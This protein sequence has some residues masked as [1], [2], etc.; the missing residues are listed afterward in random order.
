MRTLILIVVFVCVC[1]QLALA[2]DVT[3][4]ACEAS[5]SQ[6]DVEFCLGQDINI[7][8]IY[9][10]C[11]EFTGDNNTLDCQGYQIGVDPGAFLGLS[12]VYLNGGSNWDVQNC[13]VDNYDHSV[14]ASSGEN[15]T[16]SNTNHTTSSDQAF[17]FEG[18]DHVEIHDV[19]AIPGGLGGATCASS[20]CSGAYL[21]DS[22]L[23]GIRGLADWTNGVVE[24][25]NFTSV[26]AQAVVATSNWTFTNFTVNASNTAGSGFDWP[27][28]ALYNGEIYNAQQKCLE[29]SDNQYYEDLTLHH[30][31]YAIDTNPN[32]DG[33]HINRLTTHNTSIRAIR[34]Q[35]GSDNNL[36]EG[37]HLKHY[38]EGGAVYLDASMD[39][40]TFK[41]GVIEG[42]QTAPHGTLFQYWGFRVVGEHSVAD[43]P[44]GL[45]LTN[46]TFQYLDRGYAPRAYQGAVLNN[47][48]SNETGWGFYGVAIENHTVNGY[49]KEGCCQGVFLDEI[50]DLLVEASANNV[51]N[52]VYCAASSYLPGSDWRCVRIDGASSKQNEVHGINTV[53]QGT[54]ILV[55]GSQNRFDCEA[56]LL[57]GNQVFLAG[58]IES[59][60]DDNNFSNCR[61][62]NSQYGILI[63]GGDDN[64][65]THINITH[66]DY[67][68]YVGSGSDAPVFDD[69]RI[70]DGS[71]PGDQALWVHGQANNGV[72]K[73]SFVNWTDS[74]ALYFHGIRFFG[75]DTWTISGNTIILIGNYV[76]IDASRERNDAFT[77]TNNTL[78]GSGAG[79]GLL[80][81]GAD[82]T[83][84]ANNT[85]RGFTTGTS[86]AATSTGL[87]FLTNYF[88]EN[89]LDASD[90]DTA[91][92]TGNSCNTTSGN[93]ACDVAV[94]Y[95]CPAPPTP[96]VV[97]DTT[98]SDF[99]FL[100]LITSLGLMLI[101]YYRKKVKRDET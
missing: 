72:F 93:A 42:N 40:N 74:A 27:G 98:P 6:S 25:V 15:L 60:G 92:W 49:D 32:T 36:I 71:N 11:L 58:G 53:S 76:A 90:S 54:S 81:N 56:G 7:T 70:T 39:N 86:V 82:N 13:H 30:C 21:H 4:N 22:T 16:I 28:G 50:I 59:T 41:N 57:G 12:A 88:C 84:V 38:E 5:Y 9:V 8:S 66:S 48:T 45:V 46:V 17:R 100:I 67:G 101:F 96:P 55:E 34:L 87:S 10:D 47:V 64:R 18:Y 85:I 1:A 89:T 63:S 3:I 35:V 26:V 61:I 91:T 78:I 43:D 65:F 44:R 73:N 75:A 51:F 79:T 24:R 29:V 97:V 69:L 14:L 68:A 23:G 99:F 19:D 33:F 37:F 31:A 52:D 20:A 2:C 94:P 80:F 62:N 77:I 95:A 83:E